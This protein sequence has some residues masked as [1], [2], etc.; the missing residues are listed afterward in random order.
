MAEKR[1]SSDDVKKEEL[2]DITTCCIC[3]EAYTDPKALPCI[4]TFCMKCIQE[5]GLKT[6]KGP[7]DEMPC[8]ICRRLF[9]IPAEGFPGLPRHFII[10]RLIQVSKIITRS[11]MSRALCSACLEKS[12]E[13]QGKD[14][15]EAYRN[16]VECKRNLCEECCIEHAK[17]KL[18]RNHKVVPIAEYKGEKNVTPTDLTPI[19]CELHRQRVLDVYCADCE[20]VVC[21]ICFI[22]DHKNHDGSHVDKY[23]D[24]FKEEIEMNAYAI[25]QFR[26][27]AQTK[28]AA[29]LKMKE[30]IRVKVANLECDIASRADELKQ[31][32]DKHATTLLQDLRSMQQ[33]NLKEIQLAT[34][35][36]DAYLSCLETYNS[37]CQKIIAEGSASDTCRAFS[38]LSIRA[39][40]LYLQFQDL[41]KT[42]VQSVNFC[43]RKSKLEE[44][45]VG[46]CDNL[47]GEIEGK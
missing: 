34:D 40:E 32:I 11:E 16:C 21:A 2:D 29:I 8:P 14:T 4:H 41:S 1:K 20:S 45:L 13:Q 7:G 5:T 15:P 24:G 42:E 28:Q 6:N 44:F 9:K 25:N 36:I 35:D 27:T 46:S 26:S 12:E 17:N 33:S 18:T 37:Y 43:F 22:E 39:G 23:V 38:Y 3:T 10:E 19:I 47:I 30:D 31:L